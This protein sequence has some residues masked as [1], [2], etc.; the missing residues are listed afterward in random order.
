[1]VYLGHKVSG[2]EIS[3]DPQKSAASIYLP[4]T[5]RTETI[6]RSSLPLPKVYSRILDSRTPTY[7]SKEKGNGIGVARISEARFQTSGRRSQLPLNFGPFLRNSRFFYKADASYAGLGG[8]AP[9]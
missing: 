5:L 1:V 7:L 4:L 3:L 6:S 9:F 2:E 8:W